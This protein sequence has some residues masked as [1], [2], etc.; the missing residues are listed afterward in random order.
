MAKRIRYL[1]SVIVLLPDTDCFTSLYLICSTSYLLFPKVDWLILLLRLLWLIS[2]LCTTGTFT[3]ATH[4]FH[5]DYNI[6]R[7]SFVLYNIDDHRDDQCNDS[8]SQ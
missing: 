2:Y 7:F 8:N 5:R 4:R 3:L 6:P 1:E